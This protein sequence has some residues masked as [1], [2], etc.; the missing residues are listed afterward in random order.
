MTESAAFRPLHLLA[1]IAF[2]GAGHALAGDIRRAALICGGVLGLFF[3]GIFIGGID[4]IDRREDPV[5][6]YGQALVGPVAFAVDTLHQKR[7]K[8]IDPQTG[9]SRSAYPTEGR[10]PATGRAV[11]GGT[12]PNQKSIGKVNE[13]GTLYATLAGMLNLIV[14]IDAG[15]PSRRKAAAA[16]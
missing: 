4:V 7:F 2:P 6:F 12:P 15:F 8:V 1:A 5:W 9:A 10:D 11:Q 13:L 3:G 16:S 14:V